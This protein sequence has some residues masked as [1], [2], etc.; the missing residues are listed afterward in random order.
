MTV[1]GPRL[2]EVRKGADGTRP[3]ARM[4]DRRHVQSLRRLALVPEPYPGESLLS[5]VDAL[6]RLNRV[7]RLQALRLAGFARPDVSG[8]Q[9]TVHFGA[10]LTAETT[11]RVQTATGLA[12]ARQQA[13]T[14][15]HYA[16][17][18]CRRFP[19]PR[20]GGLPPSG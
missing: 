20:T 4:Q 13:M 12:A 16:V 2:T 3:H 17:A 1:S 18:F 6:A 7:G 9:P 5:W 8:Y 15:A 14:L 19:L 11:A 10:S